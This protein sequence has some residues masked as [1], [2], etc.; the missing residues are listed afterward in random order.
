[1]TP[2]G[3]IALEAEVTVL[4]DPRSSISDADRSAHDT[5]LFRSWSLQRQLTAARD[6]GGEAATRISAMRDY[7]KAAG[8]DVADA[9]RAIERI[10]ADINRALG[11]ITSA[12]G[13]AARVQAAIDSYDG[14]PTQAQLRELEWAWSD[15][16]A[17]V[18]VLNQAIA[19]LPPVYT[20]IGYSLKRQELK[21]VELK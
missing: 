11:Q 9:L 17:A 14:L 18:A 13:A 2:P 21:P 3:G 6:A 5:A 16:R 15:A 7:A 10:S 20:A 12:S 19:A 8:D 4:A 1:L